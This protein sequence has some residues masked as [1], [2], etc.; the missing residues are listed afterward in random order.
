MISARLHFCSEAMPGFGLAALCAVVMRWV[1]RLN[2][3]QDEDCDSVGRLKCVR[4][5]CREP[6]GDLASDSFMGFP[7]SDRLR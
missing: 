5:W 1:V 4:L 3:F 6:V 2:S 7:F